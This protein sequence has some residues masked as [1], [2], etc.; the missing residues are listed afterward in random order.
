M[1]IIQD[2]KESFRWESFFYRWMDQ[3]SR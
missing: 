1:K 2:R 3:S